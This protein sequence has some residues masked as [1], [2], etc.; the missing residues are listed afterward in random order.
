MRLTG[1]VSPLGWDHATTGIDS[2]S[3]LQ[4]G[5]CGQALN[6]HFLNSLD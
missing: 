1:K 6:D 5:I 4:R 3:C 2:M